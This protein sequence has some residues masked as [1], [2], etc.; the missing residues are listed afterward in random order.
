MTHR[1]IKSFFKLYDRFQISISINV[2]YVIIGANHV[3]T[4]SLL[5]EMKIFLW[6]HQHQTRAFLKVID[7]TYPKIFLEV[8]TVLLYVNNTTIDIFPIVSKS[9][10]SKVCSA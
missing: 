3:Q 10:H 1:F 6:Q 4:V 9:R 5:H 8:Y 7:E 2:T